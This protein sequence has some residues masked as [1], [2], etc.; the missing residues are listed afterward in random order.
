MKQISWSGINRRDWADSPG[1]TVGE[2]ESVRLDTPVDCCGTPTSC[3]YWGPRAA[4][5]VV[6]VGVGIR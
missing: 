5:V 3:W 6:G 1:W 2:T 4:G